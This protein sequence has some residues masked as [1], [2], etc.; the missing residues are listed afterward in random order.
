MGNVGQSNYAAAKVV[1]WKNG[2]GGDFSE[3]IVKKW[4]ALPETNTRWWFQ[5]VVISTF[6]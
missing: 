1:V 6:K 3:K 4:V 2:Q 5:I